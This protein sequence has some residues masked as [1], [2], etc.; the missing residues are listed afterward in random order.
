M[1]HDD[2]D[3]SVVVPLAKATPQDAVG[4]PTEPPAA[5]EIEAPPLRRVGRAISCG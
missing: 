2:R 5:P 4:G 3:V 1:P